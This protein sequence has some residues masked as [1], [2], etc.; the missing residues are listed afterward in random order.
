MRLTALALALLLF[1]PVLADTGRVN[2]SDNPPRLVV[3]STAEPDR[4]WPEFSGGE[5]KEATVKLNLSGVGDPSF[6]FEPQ[7]TVFV[8]D[9]SGSMAGS[10]PAFLRVVATQKYVDGMIAPDRGC[11]V[12]F[13]DKAALVNDRGLSSDYTSIKDDL[14]TVGYSS[15]TNLEAALSAA[16]K[17]LETHGQTGKMQLAILLTDGIPDPPEANVSM[18]T[19]QRILDRHVMLYTIG[20]GEDL[21][22]SLLVWLANITGGRYYHA[23]TASELE[24]IYLGISNGFKNYTAA[25]D[26]MVHEVLAPGVHLVPGSAQPLQESSGKIP[27]SGGNLTYLDWRVPALN[28]SQKW[29]AS[30]RV[31]V[32]GAGSQPLRANR[33][34]FGNDS[35]RLDYINWSGKRQVD[36]LPAVE[37]TGILPL[38]PPPPAFMPPTAPPPPPPPPPP[39]L[40]PVY[41]PAVPVA[42]QPSMVMVTQSS[43]PIY[44][45]A[46]LLGLG[47]GRLLQKV[48][49]HKLRGMGMA[50]PKSR[51]HVR[52]LVKEREKHE[53]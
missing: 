27:V 9:R 12:S 25:M 39:P 37:L 24:A 42:V 41:S 34:S 52:E 16:T 7:D 46:P 13:A 6:T 38:P 30:Y 4:I 5:P 29:T 26:I 32:T 15:G 1:Q 21:D 36:P 10:D 33:T 53:F 31:T 20:L 49:P 28:L 48:K 14:A 23:K 44:V 3:A 43:P 45:F 11:V 2:V 8:M 40:L 51:R 35:A 17:E 18:A 22:E 47:A 50:S 19:V